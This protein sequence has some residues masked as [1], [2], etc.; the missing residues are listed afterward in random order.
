MLTWDDRIILTGQ[1]L[2]IYN[3]HSIYQNMD[4]F[5]SQEKQRHICQACNKGINPVHHF[6]EDMS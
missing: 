3:N 1:T 4:T 2:P 6:Y 5:N